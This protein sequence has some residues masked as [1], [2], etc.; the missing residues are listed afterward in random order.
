MSAPTLLLI[1]RLADLS[2]LALERAPGAVAALRLLRD[3]LARRQ[4]RPPTDA[5]WTALNARLDAKLARLK[6]RAEGE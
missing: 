2:L 1:A 4:G 3:D 6:D 5:E